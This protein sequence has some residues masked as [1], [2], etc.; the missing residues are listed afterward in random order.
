MPET[1][2]RKAGYVFV[3]DDMAFR[4]E[5]VERG[6]DVDR[7]PEHDQIDDQPERAKLILLSIA[8]TLAQFAALAVEDGASKLTCSPEIMPLVS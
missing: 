3:Q 5:L 6:I 4:T 1:E 8:I 2:R 7:A